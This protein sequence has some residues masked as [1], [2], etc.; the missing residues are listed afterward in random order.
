MHPQGT[1]S[2]QQALVDYSAGNIE[3]RPEPFA[4][5]NPSIALAYKELLARYSGLC[6]R[7]RLHFNYS[8]YHRWIQMSL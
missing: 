4:E 6:K 2:I 1:S 7:E 8:P 5:L 3:D